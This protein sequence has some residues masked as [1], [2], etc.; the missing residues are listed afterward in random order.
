MK[1]K[2]KKKEHKTKWKTYNKKSF[3]APDSIMSMAAIHCKIKDD[4][5]AM[6][7]ISDCNNTVRIWNDLNKKDEPKELYLKVKNLIFSL[8][9]FQN[10]LENR[11]SIEII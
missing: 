9:E 6:V 5:I 2:K 4:G 11:F 1:N 10:E 8:K 3:L 7:R